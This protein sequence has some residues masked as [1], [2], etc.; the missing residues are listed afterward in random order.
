MLTAFESVPIIATEGPIPTSLS[1]PWTTA[2]RIPHMTSAGSPSHPAHKRWGVAETSEHVR[3]SVRGLPT[4]PRRL[5]HCRS[6]RGRAAVGCAAFD[7]RPGLTKR[8]RSRRPYDGV[9]TLL[10]LP[11]L[12]DGASH[13]LK[14][15]IATRNA[16]SLSGRCRCGAEAILAGP[17]AIGM[18]HLVFM[19]EDDCPAGDEN[20]LGIWGAEA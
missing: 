3:G 9:R 5:H 13:A 20:I 7:G 2:W 17:D 10:V 12:P 16:A 15:A 11:S 8:R 19:H 14:D 6:L 4:G 18:M 1:G